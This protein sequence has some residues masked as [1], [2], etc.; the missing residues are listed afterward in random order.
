MIFLVQCWI[1]KHLLIFV[2]IAFALRARAILLVFSKTD[3]LIICKCSCV[4]VKRAMFSQKKTIFYYASLWSLILISEAQINILLALFE[5][6]ISYSVFLFLCILLSKQKH[7]T[8]QSVWGIFFLFLL[9]K[10]ERPSILCP[11]N[12]LLSLKTNNTFIL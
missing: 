7:F 8:S 2:K 9:R 12:K 3:S 4:S 5:V 11:S 1:Y 6:L 10:A